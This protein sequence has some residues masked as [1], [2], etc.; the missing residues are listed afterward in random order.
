MQDDKGS[1]EA[2]IGPNVVK[3]NSATLQQMYSLEKSIELK[4]HIVKLYQD[5]SLISCCSQLIMFFFLFFMLHNC[6][7][8]ADNK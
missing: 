2:G 4:K 1:R 5:V 7:L 6:L 3:N 8:S